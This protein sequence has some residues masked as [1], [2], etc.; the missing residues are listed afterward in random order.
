[1]ASHYRPTDN[2]NFYALKLSSFI[3]SLLKDHTK[4]EVCMKKQS[5]QVLPCLLYSDK[6]FANSSLDNKH[7]ILEQ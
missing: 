6:H 7:I 2:D 4:D 1:M 3:E 5:D